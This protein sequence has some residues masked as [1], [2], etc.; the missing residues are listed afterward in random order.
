MIYFHPIEVIHSFNASSK[1]FI[2]LGEFNTY[3]LEYFYELKTN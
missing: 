1:V 3:Y 2:F